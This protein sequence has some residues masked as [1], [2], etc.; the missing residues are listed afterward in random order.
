MTDAKKLYGDVLYTRNEA[1]RLGVLW[2]SAKGND[3]VQKLQEYAQAWLRYG[4]LDLQL[5]E[6]QIVED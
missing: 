2:N 3:K 1:I 5:A 4:E 6:L